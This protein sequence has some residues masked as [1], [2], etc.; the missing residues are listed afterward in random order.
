MK[1]EVY[2]AYT[3]YMILK[4]AAKAN[5]VSATCALFGISRATFYNWNRAFNKYG[6]AGLE[7]KEPQKPQMPNRVNKK[8]EQ[9]ILDYVA[10]YPADGP[11]RIYYELKTEGYTIGES[12]IYNVLKRNHLSNKSER[13][14]Y[15]KSK[16]KGNNQSGKIVN[17]EPHFKNFRNE[18]PG[19]LM[20]QRLEFMGTFDGI[21][22]IYQYTI[23]DTASKWGLVQLYN[24]KQDI[25]VWQFFEF[26]L[27]YLIK[28]FNLSIKNLVTDKTKT[29]LPYFVRDDKY[30]GILENAHISHWFA[31]PE[32]TT[33]LNEMSVFSEYL[34]RGFYNKISSD[35]TLD[36]FDK[37]ERSLQKF[38]RDY[39]FSSII[40]SGLHKGKTP[41]QA[42]L[43]N[44]TQNQADLDT[45]PLGIL[46]LIQFQGR[47]GKNE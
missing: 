33:V 40:S 3:K 30:K 28:T 34:V 46:A 38:V 45:L 6:M 17:K 37:V 24:K 41:A 2:N 16:G 14:V 4:H 42:V 36:T 43:E 35:A 27:L 31:S 9:E 8:N 12:G 47:G 7:T 39:N 5:N 44:A 23:Y 26:K 15:S 13:I 25:D 29:F 19:Y 21:G 1:T 22:R 10:K 32:N 18:Q 11:K 20:T